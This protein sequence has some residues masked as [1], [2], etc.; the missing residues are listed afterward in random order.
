MSLTANAEQAAAW[1]GPEGDHWTEH[2][3]HYERLTRRYRDLLM[4]AGL[5]TLDDDVL[6]VGCG[7]GALSREAAQQV[8][9][10]TVL[11]LDLSGRMIERAR[12]L[13][14][15]AGIT[16]ARFEH[17][18]AQVHT[19]SPAGFDVIVSCFGST[20]FAD[21]VRAFTNLAESLHPGGRVGLLTWR[22]L[23]RNEWMSAI[24]DA[25]AAGR[26]LPVPIPGAPGPFGLAEADRVRA[27]LNGA[28]LV[29]VEIEPVDEAM[30]LGD[31]VAG[32]YA[33]VS[34]MGTVHGLTDDLDAARRTR[35][36]DTL[37]ATLDAHQTESGVLFDSSAWLI[38]ARRR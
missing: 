33:L 34:G 17:A 16:N 35:A 6:D 19:F 20:F 12:E 1:D 28:G 14:A 37:R 5:L 27:L 36:F 30:K 31:D 29:D 22:D 4:S 7:T 10:G 25:L 23:A 38:T 3:E 24:R 18:D 32:A 26:S 13:T 15:A 9:A 2:A 11:G 21:P 8:P